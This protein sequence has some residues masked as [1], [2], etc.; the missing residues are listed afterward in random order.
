MQSAEAGGQL[1]RRGGAVG[2]GPALL[3]QF[4]EGPCLFLG[5][6]G[7]HRRVLSRG[8]MPSVSGFLTI[9]LGC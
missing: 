9:T 4:V 7:G 3:G 6:M 2:A 5:D 8:V 1:E